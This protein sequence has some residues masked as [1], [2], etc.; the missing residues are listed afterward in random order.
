MKA[1]LF[2][3]PV[4]ML[5]AAIAWA[6]H[7][8]VHRARVASWVA[9]AR[10]NA[11]TN[12]VANRPD[13]TAGGSKLFQERCSACHGDDARGTPRGPDLAKAGVQSQSDGALFWKISS[14]NTRTGMPAFSFLP[15]THRWQLVLHLRALPRS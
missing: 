8:D 6:G 4:L 9:P 3:G 15:P 14:G 12:P 7:P 2:A 11:M 13:A 5:G 10:A 1:T